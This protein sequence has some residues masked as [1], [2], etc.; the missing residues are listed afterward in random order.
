MAERQWAKEKI[1]KIFPALAQKAASASTAGTLP[2]V[3]Y[4]LALIMAIKTTT[5]TIPTIPLSR[6]VDEKQDKY[7][8]I[9]RSGLNTT[10]FMCGKDSTGDIMDLPAWMQ[11]FVTKGTSKY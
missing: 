5:M 3:P 2:Q 11:D 1:P 9:S 6:T 7:K 10:L 8:E 4:L